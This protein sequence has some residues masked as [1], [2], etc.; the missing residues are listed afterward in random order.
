MSSNSES[1]IWKE[2]SPNVLK[3]Y[4]P[5]IEF[6]LNM[7]VCCNNGF[8]SEVSEIK[9]CKPFRL[10]G[11]YHGKD[12]K[13]VHKPHERGYENNIIFKSTLTFSLIEAYKKYCQENDIKI[14]TR[15]DLVDNF[16]ECCLKENSVILESRTVKIYE[17]FI[18]KIK[19]MYDCGMR[20]GIIDLI[21]IYYRF[22]YKNGHLV[23]SKTR[24]NEYHANTLEMQIAEDI[25]C[26][27]LTDK[28]YWK[29]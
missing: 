12:V 10:V 28:I 24:K 25:D 5:K 29:I 27:T 18:E 22:N 9:Y 2:N 23:L 15:G 11:K 4:I 13:I 6:K 20:C 19:E 7:K 21:Q 3:L 26:N 14:D 17:D 1:I 8:S 16:L